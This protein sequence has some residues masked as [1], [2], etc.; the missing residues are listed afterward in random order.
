MTDD[1]SAGTDPQPSLA[2]RLERL[3][4]TMRRRD[5]RPMSNAAAAKAIA[6]SISDEDLN[7]QFIMPPVFDKSVSQRVAEA[8]CEAAIA[9]GV[10]RA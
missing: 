2:A 9:D 4:D 8:V 10:T 3:F 1:G 6:E 5:E 7:E